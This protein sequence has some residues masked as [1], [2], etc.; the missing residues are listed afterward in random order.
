MARPRNSEL[1]GEGICW[2]CKKWKDRFARGLCAPCFDHVRN[3]ISDPNALAGRQDRELQKAP[4]R[5]W[6]II[7]LLRQLKLA[8][9]YDDQKKKLFYTTMRIHFDDLLDELRDMSRSELKPDLTE[10]T[11]AIEQS[12]LADDGIAELKAE[13]ELEKVG[14]PAPPNVPPPPTTPAP[15][16][17]S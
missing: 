12:D 13:L 4:Q 8:G 3:E 16:G 9:L 15:K 2:R 11:E 5:I 17:K 6:S 7:T 10:V 1:T 14:N